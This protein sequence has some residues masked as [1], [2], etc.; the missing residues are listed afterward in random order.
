[1]APRERESR[2]VALAVGALMR[3]ELK[4]SDLDD[5]DE[6][7]AGEGLATRGRTKHLVMAQATAVP[8]DDPDLRS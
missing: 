2:L 5:F 7:V 6:K 3:G 1:M 4:V 8:T